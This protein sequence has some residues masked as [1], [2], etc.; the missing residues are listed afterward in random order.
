M[1]AGGSRRSC[2]PPR[3]SQAARSVIRGR[4]FGEFFTHSTGHGI[5]LELHELP[6]VNRMNG[7]KLPV[8]SVV[9]VEP[10]IY[11]DGLG[12][13]RIEDDVIVTP[14]GAEVITSASGTELRL[15]SP[16]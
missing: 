13:V 3:Q 10:G 2:L 8:G 11:I 7:E 1:I 6:V 12:G 15:L 14:H 16:A 5:G 9:T 4:G